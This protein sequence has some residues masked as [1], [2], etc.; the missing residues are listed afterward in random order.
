ME[1]KTEDDA[2]YVVKIM[3]MIKIFG[4]PIRCNKASQD[5]RARGFAL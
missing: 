2:D 3:N 5:K 4:K 1:F